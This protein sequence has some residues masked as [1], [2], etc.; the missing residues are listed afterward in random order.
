MRL[1]VRVTPAA[2]CTFS[3]SSTLRIVF[4]IAMA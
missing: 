2:F 4:A 1:D 3:W